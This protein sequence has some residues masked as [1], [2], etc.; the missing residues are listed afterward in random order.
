MDKRKKKRV[1]IKKGSSKIPWKKKTRCG[2]NQRS[3]DIHM[4]VLCDLDDQHSLTNTWDSPHQYFLLVLHAAQ[5]NSEDKIRRK[6]SL[7]S[8]NSS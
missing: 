5:I 6:I 2:V 1:Y 8:R 4:L 7:K 3:V